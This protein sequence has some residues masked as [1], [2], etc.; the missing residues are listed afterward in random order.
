MQ[1]LQPAISTCVAHRYHLMVTYVHT[2]VINMMHCYTV[3]AA[4]A[5]TRTLISI[6]YYVRRSHF[7][8]DQ[9]DQTRRTKKE[10][11]SV[12]GVYKYG[13]NHEHYAR[14]NIVDRPIIFK[15]QR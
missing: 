2:R 6:V 8:I 13:R 12:L 5:K 11:T 14:G 4:Y 7:S 15:R 3:G 1:V 10:C 9:L